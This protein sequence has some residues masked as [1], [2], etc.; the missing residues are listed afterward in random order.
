MSS[1]WA[2]TSLILSSASS[3]L[4]VWL[5]KLISD[6]LFFSPCFP[7]LTTCRQRRYARRWT[8]ALTDTQSLPIPPQTGSPRAACLPAQ[9]SS[10]QSTLA[11]MQAIHMGQPLFSSFGCRFPLK[12]PFFSRPPFDPKDHLV[13]LH[14]VAHLRI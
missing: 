4:V 12:N 1:E 7:H 13:S 8:S 3:S 5:F 9:S 11:C 10:G 6:S 2:Q 14:P